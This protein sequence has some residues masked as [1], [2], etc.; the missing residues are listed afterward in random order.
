[1]SEQV[2]TSWGSFP[3]V[4]NFGHR[5]IQDLLTGEVNV[6]EKVDGSQFSFGCFHEYDNLLPDGVE[7]RGNPRVELKIKSKGAMIYPDAPPGLF[8]GAVDTVKALFAEGK[9]TPGW[10]YRGEA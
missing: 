8:K 6:E 10:T 3:Q 4:Y 1:M 2:S 7:W 9:L 5:A